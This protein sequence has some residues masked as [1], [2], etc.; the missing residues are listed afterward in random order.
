MEVPA[1]AAQ[2]S[3]DRFLLRRVAVLIVNHNTGA[4]LERCLRTLQPGLGLG[5]EVVVVDNASGDGSVDMVRRDFAGVSVV[6]ADANLGFGRGENLAA[7][8]TQRD[9]LL[10]LNPDCFIEPDSIARLAASLDGNPELGFVGPRID[11]ESGRPDHACL[12]N[13]PDPVGALLY[14]SRLPRLFRRPSLN[15]YSLAHADYDAEQELQAG[16]AACLMV[17]GADFRAVGGFD[18]AFF[19]YG[20][21]LDLCRRLRAAGHPGRYVPGAHALHLKGEASRK[22]SG[23]MLVEFHRAMWI[24]YRKHEQPHHAAPV[25]WAVAAGIG[26]L[27]GA[28][29]A[30]NAARKEKLVSRR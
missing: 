28:R 22:Q 12:R 6:E 19:M 11:L 26:V 4:V 8:H 21:D 13:D 1:P 5:L 14:F 30:L 2:A 7:S 10:I 18:E 23:R 29:L 9:F 24:Y 15:R 20:E 17:R 16:T 27:G 25:N 3:P